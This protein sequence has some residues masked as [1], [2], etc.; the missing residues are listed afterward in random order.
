M[1][2]GM[3][4]TRKT[5]LFRVSIGVAV[6]CMMLIVEESQGAHKK[7]LPH[8]EYGNVVINNYSIKNKITPVVFNHWLHRT[9]YTCRYCHEYLGFALEKNKT[10]ITE[11]ANQKGKYCGACHNGKD[12]FGPKD[13]GLSGKT[14]SKNC[15]RCHSYDK[16]VSFD[17]NFYKFTEK[18][19]RA[20]FGNG[21]NW[22]KA[23]EKKNI[24]LRDA[25]KAKSD[26][27]DLNKNLSDS[28]IRPDEPEMPQIIFSHDKH[29]RWNGCSLCHPSIFKE[30]K[31]SPKITMEG[32]FDGEFCG[33]CHGRVAFPTLDCQRC[34]TQPAIM[35]R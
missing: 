16:K 33:V 3:S 15:D 1:I 24:T 34:H 27:S 8:H 32:I 6:L 17:K 20:R 2:Q 11:G 25:P 13:K 26:R 22:I 5:I 18:L 7:R 30:Q 23:A 10:G 4:K 14:L 19:P 35:E 12:A 21:I 9:Q 28:L 31:G 29:A